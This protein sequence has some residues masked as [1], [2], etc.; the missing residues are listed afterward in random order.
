MI[1]KIFFPL[2]VMTIRALSSRQFSQPGLPPKGI[3]VLWEAGA[4]QGPRG[5]SAGNGEQ[6]EVRKRRGPGISHGDLPA[7]PGHCVLLQSWK[8]S[9][10]RVISLPLIP[11]TPVPPWVE[12]FHQRLLYFANP[13]ARGRRS[14]RPTG[15]A[16]GAQAP[17]DAQPLSPRHG[18]ARAELLLLEQPR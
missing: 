4:N 17:G 10:T 6:T 18:T 9:G 8:F 14:P 12:V 11:A 5:P 2:Q 15:Q 7:H 1:P 3:F 13:L 16:G